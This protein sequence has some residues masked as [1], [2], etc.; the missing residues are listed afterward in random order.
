VAI[1]TDPRWALDAAHPR[2]TLEAADASASE[3]T[4]GYG[5]RD[6]SNSISKRGG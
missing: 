1:R 3:I 4:L 5:M 2:S 6:T